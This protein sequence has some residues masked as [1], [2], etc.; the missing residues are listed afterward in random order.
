MN[1]PRPPIRSTPL[2]HLRASDLR[3]IAQL[4]TQ[5]TVGVTRIAEG[6]HQSVLSTLGG[7]QGKTPGQTRGVTGLVYRS[8]EGIARLLGKG[9]DSVMARLQPLLE[10]TD[11]A[12]PESPQ[13][14]AVLAALNG[15]MGDRLAASGSPFATRMTLRFNGAEVQ[16][17]ALPPA[18]GAGKKAILLIH[19]LCMND[20][21]WQTEQ[22]GTVFD[23]GAAIGAVL[24][25]PALYLRYNS[26]RHISENGAELSTLLEHVLGR[27]GNTIEQL[28][29]VAHSMGGL[30]IRSA[31]HQAKL[32]GLHW[33]A[34]LKTIVFL[35][36]P[37]HGAPLERAG[38]WI[39]EVLGSTPWSAPFARLGQ[40][41][42]A[43]IT[44]LRY[45][46]VADEDWHGHERFRR[47]PD[48][49]LHVPLP[50]GV[51]CYTVAATVAA[52][53]SPLADRLVGDGLVPLESALGHHAD[54]L[55]TLAF[56]KAS[57]HI[58]WRTHH[59][60]LL[61]SP[62]VARQVAAWLT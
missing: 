48:R 31:L 40:L 62:D 33:P 5:A 58:V 42:S 55:R 25:A 17:G 54:P 39:D 9:A 24:Q 37:H 56:A 57:Q 30:L 3:G 51:A 43:G 1:A 18:L 59:M 60:A 38:N 8:V 35:G 34:A 22:D 15:V 29:V 11:A 53:R 19:G 16:P 20:L 28:T 4:A 49:R 32:D 41:R 27:P 14:E 21:Q 36:T 61:H 52:K 45:G 12:P 2:R 23:H 44:D 13:R 50:D 10:L 26:G 47:Q 7:A 46:F 6:V